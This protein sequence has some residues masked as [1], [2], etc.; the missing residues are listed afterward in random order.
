MPRLQKYVMVNVLS[1]INA[2]HILPF[3]KI[4]FHNRIIFPFTPRSFTT[5]GTL[6]V[7]GS[8][9]QFVVILPKAIGHP[10]LSLYCI[11]HQQALWE[12]DSLCSNFVAT[13]GNSTRVVYS[14]V[15]LAL[16]NQHF[17]TFLH[18]TISESCGL[19]NAIDC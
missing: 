7:V 19:N 3:S 15:S 13:D 11:L 2:I 17:N 18:V 1:R 10:T 5:D 12:K 8:T 4:H 6:S 16:N 14:I 9:A